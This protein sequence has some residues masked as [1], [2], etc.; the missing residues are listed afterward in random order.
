[1]PQLVEESHPAQSATSNNGNLRPSSALMS[2]RHAIRG[3]CDSTSQSDEEMETPEDSSPASS[4]GILPLPPISFSVPVMSKAA[5][6]QSYKEAASIET[7]TPRVNMAT[8][9]PFSYR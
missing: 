2:Y 9:A 6:D 3:H 1:M 7:H 5:L 8:V 4:P